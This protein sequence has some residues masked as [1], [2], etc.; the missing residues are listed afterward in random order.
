MKKALMLILALMFLLSLAACDGGTTP[1]SEPS[2]ETESSETESLEAVS[3]EAP[4][5][6]ATPA[7]T[8][9]PPTLTP[10][11][12][13][14]DH[15]GSGDVLFDIYAHTALVDLNGDGTPEELTFT[16]GG[17]SSTMQIGSN[18]YTIDRS[19][20][21]QLFAV[22]DVDISDGILELA[23]TDEY[24]GELADTEFPFTYLYWWDGTDLIKMG[25]LMDMKFAGAWRSEFDPT[26]NFDA[27]GMVM[28]LTR[29][30]NFSDTWYTGHYMPNG[31]SRK[32]K[33]DLY[34]APVLFHQEPLVLKQYILLLKKIDNTYFE[35]SYQVMWDY[36][37]GCGGMAWQP[38]DY[39]DDIIAFIPQAGEELTIIKVYGKK[40]FKLQASDGKSG[41][42]KC[43][44]MKVYGYWPT[45]GENYTADN[46]FGGIVI[47][48]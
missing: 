6:A 1:S 29:T 48:G 34:A 5:V 42:L 41:W 12:E 46:L 28:C 16:A 24:D 47:A 23:F 15:A 17:S 30:Q 19:N 22:T 20:Q 3:S 2:S 14:P 38:R 25:G 11:G 9:I 27:H 33:E 7:S 37:S 39:S 45:M 40:W 31:T 10:F 36:A 18:T 13:E 44:N 32:L 21:A 8:P 26:D 43:E 35:F 4:S